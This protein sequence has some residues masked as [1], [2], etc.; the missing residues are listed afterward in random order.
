MGFIYI[1]VSE[2]TNRTIITKQNLGKIWTMKD[3]EVY[4]LY[5]EFDIENNVVICGGQ[6]ESAWECKESELI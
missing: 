4:D 2:A 5:K 1:Y 3:G 6:F